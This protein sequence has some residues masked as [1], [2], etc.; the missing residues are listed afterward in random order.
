[1]NNHNHS[2]S[3]HLNRHVEISGQPLDLLALNTE[4]HTNQGEVGAIVTFTGV[5]RVS[6]EESGLTGMTLEHYQGMTEKQLANILE[7]AESRW[8]LS[9]TFV[10]HRVGYME[11]G[12]PIVFVAT[13]GSHRKAAFEAAEF[14]MDYLKNR[15]TFWKK[16]HYGDKHQWV[17]AKQSDLEAI[18]RWQ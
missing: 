5:V 2:Y 6:N 10:V 14:I 7:E 3:H 12:E 9:K 11:P 16:E 1:M 4:A 18:K 17:D 13:C 15:A 8:Q